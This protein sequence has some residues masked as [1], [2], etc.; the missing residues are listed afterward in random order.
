MQPGD[1]RDVRDT[2]DVRDV[3][4][5]P[6]SRRSPGGGHGNPLQCSCLE[7]PLDRGACRATVHRV[8]K[9]WTRLNQLSTN[10]CIWTWDT[11]KRSENQPLQ[12]AWV[13]G[14]SL[15]VGLSILKSGQSQG[16]GN[17]WSPFWRWKWLLGSGWV[18]LLRNMAILGLKD[19]T[20]QQVMGVGQKYQGVS[21]ISKYEEQKGRIW[22]SHWWV[23]R[24]QARCNKHCETL[25]LHPPWYFFIFV[26]I[27]EWQVLLKR[28]QVMKWFFKNL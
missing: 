14:I 28:L 16:D 11:R 25:K 13:Q 3:G 8:S 2:G 26:L 6:G 24:I 27:G 17:P 15:E 4:S 7:N 5:I 20:K 18:S 10:E 1:V 21:I 12:S 23:L 9:S 19:Y 22:G